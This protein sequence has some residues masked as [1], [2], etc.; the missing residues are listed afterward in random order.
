MRWQKI[1]DDTKLF[2]WSSSE[3]N[4]RNFSE[5]YSKLDT[6]VTRCQI[7]FKVDKRKPVITEEEKT[8]CVL[9][10]YLCQWKKGF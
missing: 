7:K 1:A 10:N 6:L 8:S 2:G 4:A 3:R 5:S 9:L